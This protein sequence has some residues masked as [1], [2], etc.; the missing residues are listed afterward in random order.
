MS[1]VPP[2]L[3]R[4]FAVHFAAD[5]AA[6]VPLFLAPGAVLGLLGW[7]AVDPLASRLVAAALLGIGI[8]SLLGRGADAAT[9]RAMLNLKIIWSGAATLGCLWSQLQD[10]GPWGGWAILTIF[11]GSHALWVH[12]RLRLRVA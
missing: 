1:E 10:G 2:S 9:F 8:E 5:L 6:A 12:Y 4:W 11:V 3:R 7:Q